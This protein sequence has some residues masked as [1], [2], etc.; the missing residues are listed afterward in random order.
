MQ[1]LAKLSI[2]QIGVSKVRFSVGRGLHT[3]T[4]TYSV[5]D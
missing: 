1:E 4:I 5:K 3:M 2:H